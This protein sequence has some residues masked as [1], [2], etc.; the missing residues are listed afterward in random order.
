[1][2]HTDDILDM[3]Q[4]IKDMLLYLGLA[5]LGVALIALFRGLF[6]GCGLIICIIGLTQAKYA[7]DRHKVVQ[8]LCN[9]SP[10]K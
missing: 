1:M 3:L 4:D 6:A 8:S 5:I 7:H 9:Q 2:N 10:R